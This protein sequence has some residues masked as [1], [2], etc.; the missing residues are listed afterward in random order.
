MSFFGLS[1]KVLPY[2]HEQSITRISRKVC[3]ESK[4]L[5]NSWMFSFT[6]FLASNSQKMNKTKGGSCSSVLVRKQIF[7][8]IFPKKNIDFCLFA[9][10]LFK[11]VKNFSYSSFSNFNSKSS[12]QLHLLQNLKLRK[13]ALVGL[14]LSG[15]SCRN[16]LLSAKGWTS[17]SAIAREKSDWFQRIS[18]VC[19]N[20]WNCNLTE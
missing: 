16:V 12:I 19:R 11:Q 15:N 1:I 7:L 4:I 5:S 18:L 14:K 6:D 20:F 17:S 3:Y 9:I 2:K 8:L 10:E 13:N